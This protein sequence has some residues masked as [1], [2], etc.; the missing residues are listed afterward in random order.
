MTENFKNRQ[1]A[2]KKM[3]LHNKQ[4]ENMTVLLR[5][6]R[7]GDEMDMIAC[8]RDE[9]GDTYFKRAFYDP[10]HLKREAKEGVITFLV[11]E[12]QDGEIAGMMILKQFYPD[13]FMC[14]IASQIFLKKY[15][16]FGM[17]MPFFEYGMDILLS[18]SYSAAFCLPVLF[19][20]VTQRLLYRL[21][22]RATGLV[23]NV[24][25]MDHIMHS[26]CNGRNR[27]HSQGIQVRAIG[28]K[29]TGTLYIPREH[30]PFCSKIYDSLGAK[31]HIRENSNEKEEFSGYSGII[32]QNNREQQSLEIRIYRVGADF[33]SQMEQIH[34]RYPLQGKQ[35]A[36]V[37]LNCNDPQ[38]IYAYR[39]LKEMGYFFTGL[40]PLCSDREYMVLHHPGEVGIWFEDYV[41]SDEFSVLIT[42]VE[43]NYEEQKRLNE[44]QK[45]V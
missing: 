16:G 9:Y 29:D 39:V 17:A 19:H 30:V 33:K 6:Y 32:C 31:C 35:T 10:E 18:R 34:I 23:M 7:E 41:V 11:A 14:E 26:Y 27:K 44:M 37:F 20:D 2:E 12:T 40:K 15:R 3:T 45:R 36:N 1:Q 13:E 5:P 43:A 4:G 42:Y 24:F 25:D 28:K 38:A 21:G 22:L 8:I